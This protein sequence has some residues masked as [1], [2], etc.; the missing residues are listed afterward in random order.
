MGG[1]TRF[2]H[3]QIQKMS[4][5]THDNNGSETIFQKTVKG[6]A[7]AWPILGAIFILTTAGAQAYAQISEHDAQIAALQLITPD[8]T[9]RLA[10]LE[11]I[12]KLQIAQLERIEDKLDALLMGGFGRDGVDGTNGRDGTNGTNGTNGRNLR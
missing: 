11:T 12:Q 6:I 1:D 7:S 2:Q 4:P 3:D 10:R 9:D 5:Y 8:R